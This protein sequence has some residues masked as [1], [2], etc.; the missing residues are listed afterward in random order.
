MSAVDDA[1]TRDPI[2]ALQAFV[3]GARWFG[4]KGRDGQLVGLEQPDWI[5]EPGEIGRAHV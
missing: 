4:G 1:T 3:L 5:V 2:E